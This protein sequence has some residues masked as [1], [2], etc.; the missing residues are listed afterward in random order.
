MTPA[1]G[2]TLCFGLG[3][4]YAAGAVPLFNFGTA[5]RQIWAHV[6][7]IVTPLANAAGIWPWL[8]MWILGFFVVGGPLALVW[9]MVGNHANRT[10]WLVYG[11]AAFG[12]W[13]ISG[14]WPLT[15]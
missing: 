12:A 7:S 15:G 9:L 3:F 13:W 4:L 6:E 2:R 10:L 11:M 14:Y 8:A 5:G 1:L